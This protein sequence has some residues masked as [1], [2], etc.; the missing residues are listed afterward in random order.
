M[1]LNT[2]ALKPRARYGSAG[3]TYGDQ[4]FLSM[5]W[6]AGGRRL[7]DTWALNTT[8]GKYLGVLGA[9]FSLAP[10]RRRVE[11]AS[12]WRRSEPVQPFPAAR[13]QHAC[14]GRGGPG[15]A[16]D[17]QWMRKVSNPP[18]YVCAVRTCNFAR[19]RRSDLARL[20]T[21]KGYNLSVSGGSE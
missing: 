13:S 1:E 17:V 18:I 8:S 7:S 19:R 2:S 10:I 14:W 3:G 9:A 6:S 5:G 21:D 12:G 15:P 11:R 16:G 20:F 4:L